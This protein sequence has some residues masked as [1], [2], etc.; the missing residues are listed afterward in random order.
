MGY[1]A[2]KMFFHVYIFYM[3]AS[4]LHATKQYIPNNTYLHHSSFSNIRN[5][6]PGCILVFIRACV[7]YECLSL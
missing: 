2:L 5:Q 7:F 6:A 4:L 1:R 3:H